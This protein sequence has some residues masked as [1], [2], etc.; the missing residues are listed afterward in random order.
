MPA[1][2]SYNQSK[3]RN[4]TSRI[5]ISKVANLKRSIR[6]SKTQN[7]QLRWGEN[8]SPTFFPSM[9][10]TGT[11]RILIQPMGCSLL[12]GVVLCEALL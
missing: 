11:P 3:V 2:F 1:L 6:D 5:Q 9:M 4:L 10:H 8:L 12:L 7:L